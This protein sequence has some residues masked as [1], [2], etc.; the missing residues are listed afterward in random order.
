MDHVN[1]RLYS[2]VLDLF[3]VLIGWE[4]FKHCIDVNEV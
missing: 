2:M 3:Y 1:I 4:I